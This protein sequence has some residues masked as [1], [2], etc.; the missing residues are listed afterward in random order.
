MTMRSLFLQHLAQTSAAP[1]MVEIERAE[2]CRLYGPTGKSWLDFISGIGV[3]NVG[4]NAKEVVEA[5]HKQAD[6]YLHTMVYGE[7]ILSPQVKYAEALCAKLQPDF[8]QVYFVNSGSEAV[9]GALKLA[10]K[11]TG[12]RRMVAFKNA[13]HGS[14]HGALSVTDCARLKEGYGPLLP[15][16]SHIPF[17]D[18]DALR[19][20]DRECACVIVEPIQ[21]EAGVILPQAKFLKAIRE[22][23]TQTG[24]LLIFDEIQTGMGRTGS[25]FAFQDA[26][27][28]PDILLLAK[29]LGGGLPLGAF[30]ARKEIM[31]AL[32]T[33]PPLGHITTFG[34]HPLSCAAGQAA[35]EILMNQRLELKAK[36]RELQLRKR[37]LH[38]EILEIRGKGLLLALQ[39]R[40]SEKVLDTVKKGLEKGIVV[41]WFLN[42]DDCIRI[43]PPL[44]ISEEE[45]DEGISILLDCLG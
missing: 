42:A 18:F 9:E 29:A 2:G 16:V 17:N 7:F 40:S 32:M 19:E 23:C 45:L 37:L 34:G 33:S 8:D 15:E 3:S 4:H 20:I 28:I 44:V 31:S 26:G 39:L 43:A 10:K 41:D 35:F 5:I 13:Y 36:E 30:I 38:P 21:A 14:T 12:K 24:A 22:R 27:V 25:L 6:S 11:F 1:L